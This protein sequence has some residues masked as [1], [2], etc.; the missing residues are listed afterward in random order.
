[1]RLVIFTHLSD[2]YPQSR[3][4]DIRGRFVIS[5]KKSYGHVGLRGFGGVAQLGEDC[6][7]VGGVGD[8]GWVGGRSDN[9]KVVTKGIVAG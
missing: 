3:F 7:D 1:M 9:D 5:A 4:L 8:V 6:E 2:S